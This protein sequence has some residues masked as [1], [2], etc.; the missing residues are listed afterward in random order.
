MRLLII[1]D[2]RFTE[3]R[4]VL[5]VDGS[6]G[7]VLMVPAEIAKNEELLGSAKAAALL[8][9]WDRESVAQDVAKAL[10]RQE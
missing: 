3:P 10:P 9:Y 6:D 4:L 5:G 2:S 1:D 8:K 7:P